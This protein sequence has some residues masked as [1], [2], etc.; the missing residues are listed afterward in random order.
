MN[1]DLNNVGRALTSLE[2]FLTGNSFEGCSME[3]DFHIHET[4]LKRNPPIPQSRFWY[5][6]CV[7]RDIAFRLPLISFLP[8]ARIL[9]HNQ[10]YMKHFIFWICPIVENSF[11]VEVETS[12]KVFQEDKQ[13]VIAQ[14]A[15]VSALFEKEQPYTL[16]HR[17]DYL[18]GYGYGSVRSRVRVIKDKLPELK[19]RIEALPEI[20]TKSPTSVPE[21][22]MDFLER[23][24]QKGIK[25]PTPAAIDDYRGFGMVSKKESQ[26]MYREAIEL[27][28]KTKY[29]AAWETYVQA[30]KCDL[31]KGIIPEL[32]PESLIYYILH[33][34]HIIDTLK[35][36]EIRDFLLTSLRNAA[37]LFKQKAIRDVMKTYPDFSLD[38][39]QKYPEIALTF[40]IDPQFSQML[41]E[42]QIV[43]MLDSAL[44]AFPEAAKTN[45]L[46]AIQIKNL[47]NCISG[48]K[49]V[50]TSHMH[51]FCK[52]IEKILLLP[53][54]K[55]HYLEADY[56]GLLNYLYIVF[57]KMHSAGIF[58]GSGIHID[59]EQS[60]RM[61]STAASGSADFV[62]SLKGYLSQEEA[63]EF[64]AARDLQY[65]LGKFLLEN[66]DI[67]A[68]E[69]RFEA[70]LKAA[71][72]FLSSIPK[73]APRFGEAM[74]LC[75]ELLL[76]H[77][78]TPRWQISEYFKSALDK[79]VSQA[80]LFYR[81]TK[82]LHATSPDNEV[83]YIFSGQEESFKGR[84]YTVRP[85][86]MSEIS[87]LGSLA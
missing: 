62:E 40:L 28:K 10:Q 41:Q 34:D 65:V 77:T 44:K 73:E 31:K 79:G 48:I 26:D 14:I 55:R 42:E 1:L 80:S 20:G 9:Y 24:I 47:F 63:S 6:L 87:N 36:D 67:E 75:G 35:P 66:P 51:A 38:V 8:Q 78:D 81:T 43:K 70:N 64:E 61:Y 18:R 12:L 13:K 46:S 83:C 37:C 39:A 33:Q 27:C 23:A 4:L 72:E 56:K 32:P 17:I 68:D 76:M 7:I 57:G 11:L 59:L 5:C 86:E 54:V 52:E 49:T 21:K 69:A 22:H 2:A 58:N 30:Q 25:Q 19:K 29:A 60:A 71:F 50:Y 45:S 16:K 53:E 3:Y 74:F 85:L 15:K 82:Y 84:G